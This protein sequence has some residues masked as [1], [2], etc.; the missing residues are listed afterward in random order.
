MGIAGIIKGYLEGTII[1]ARIVIEGIIFMPA[2]TCNFEVG[3]DFEHWN[4]GDQI[5]L[6]EDVLS[7]NLIFKPQT[8][9][10][11]PQSQDI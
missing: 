10:P 3:V 6:I 7:D 1:A 2:T 5:S 4:F 11:K 9:N 8:P